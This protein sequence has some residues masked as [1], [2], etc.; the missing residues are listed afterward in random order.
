M[1]VSRFAPFDPPPP[2]VDLV[3][4]AT[5]RA[6]AEHAALLERER[7]RQAGSISRKGAS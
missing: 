4:I 6:N 1:I 7:L 5:A 2:R 3:Q